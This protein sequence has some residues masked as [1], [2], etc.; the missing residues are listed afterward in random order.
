MEVTAVGITYFEKPSRD[1]NI[2]NCQ[3]IG[4]QLERT[5]L[6]PIPRGLFRPL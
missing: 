4:V 6:N 2:D 3:Q 1:E 5:L